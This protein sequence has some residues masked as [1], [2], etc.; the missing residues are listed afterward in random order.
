MGFAATA[1]TRCLSILCSTGERH[2]FPI[3]TA[4]VVESQNNGQ[5]KR[6]KNRYHGFSDGSPKPSSTYSKLY[7]TLIG[8]LLFATVLTP[9]WEYIIKWTSV[10]AAS[11]PK[12]ESSDS[13][14]HSSAALEESKGGE[15]EEEED[16]KD[17][18]RK[19]KRVGFRDRKIIEYENRIRDYSTPDK[20]FRYFATLRVHSE[21]ME[22]E[23]YM[24]PDDFVRSITPGAKQNEG[25]GLD[26]FKRYDPKKDTVV[27][28]LPD[29]S[30]FWKLGQHG[31]ISFSD[32]VFL[33]VV[34]STPPRMFEIAFKMFDLN[35]DGDLEFEEFERVREVL[36]SQSSVGMRHRDHA[37]TGNTLKAMSSG[38]SSY[39]FGPKL[40]QKLTVEK[41]LD[42][43]R[44]LQTEILRLEFQR[45]ELETGKISERDFAE[46]LIA[47]AGHNAKKRIKMMRRVKKEFKESQKGITFQ[48]YLDFFQVLKFINDIDTALMFYHVAGASIDKETL[49]HVAKTVAH[50]NLSDHLV[51]VVFVLFDENDDGELS[52]KEFV[53]VMKR[54]MMRGLEKPK[55]TGLVKLL[56]AMWKCAKVQTTMAE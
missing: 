32:Y 33:L 14:E 12:V 36:R 30:I 51:D 52:N 49:K 1:S 23:V 35:G 48:E 25:Y 17:K 53:A 29:S 8:G 46:S 22:P 28:E 3:L 18:K 37:V 42:F 4:A 13:K 21:G 9:M 10:E 55:D 6:Y 16:D 26:Q 24:T 43:Q 41:F 56:D 39:F 20:I 15:S 38:L 7:Y 2:S 11:V 27:C 45:Y 19:K 34:L 5:R 50:V 40:D 47:Y 31:L 44:Q 54:R